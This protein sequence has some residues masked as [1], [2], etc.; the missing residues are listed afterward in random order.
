MLTGLALTASCGRTMLPG[1]SVPSAFRPLIP[2]DAK[3][4]AAVDLDKLKATP[5]YQRHRDELN[6]PLL[7]AMSERVGLDPRRDLSYVLVAWTGPSLVAMARGDI[8][9]RDLEQ[10]LTALGMRRTEYKSRT[11]FGDNRDA[12][13]LDSHGM[14]LAGPTAS[15]RAEIDLANGAIPEELRPRLAAVPRGDQL[16]AVSRGDLT[17]VQDSV[18]SDVGSALSN[19]T[20]FISG[21]SFGLGFDTG[22]HLQAEIL[23]ISTEGA[24]RVRDALRGGI[25]LARLTTKD[26]ETE[27]LQAYDAVQVSQDQQTVR[28]KADF[29]ANLTDKLLAHLPGLKAR[30]GEML[31]RQ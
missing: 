12:L 29:S 15:V 3:V 6:I 21:I 4:L 23:C 9:P 24:Q 10:R 26:N 19:I 28:V 1:V 16:W 7:N 2:P 17:F 27:L 31:Q 8:K 30:A 22:V 11:V 13:T 20:G 18:R 5:F 14:I 25:G